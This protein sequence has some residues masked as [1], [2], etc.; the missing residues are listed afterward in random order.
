[1]TCAYCGSGDW[2][3]DTNTIVKMK[4]LTSRVEIT[5]LCDCRSCG[6]HFATTEFYILR[7]TWE[8]RKLTEKEIEEYGEWSE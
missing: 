2:V 6:R 4:R 5:Y 8:S 1:M 3:E 7:Q